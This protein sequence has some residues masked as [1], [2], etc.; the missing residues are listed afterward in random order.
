MAT[1]IH[2]LSP[3]SRR[4]QLRTDRWVTTMSGARYK[5]ITCKPRRTTVQARQDG[6]S[7]RCPN[8]EMEIINNRQDQPCDVSTYLPE[9]GQLA[10]SQEP[11]N[12]AF[13]LQ[14]YTVFAMTWRTRAQGRKTPVN[15]T[16][17]ARDEMQKKKMIRNR[18]PAM[19]PE[20]ES[21][22][23]SSDGQECTVGSYEQGPGSQLSRLQQD[24]WPRDPDLL[25]HMTLL[26]P[27]DL[28]TTFVQ[29]R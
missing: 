20:I 17:C 24:L 19:R 21:S 28:Q 6:L 26:I 5:T 11:H 22:I 13:D 2:G 12:N 9:E 25:A 1:C 7:S 15:P 27:P 10:Y 18:S 4:S 8:D 29:F 14:I 23:P 3:V 16:V